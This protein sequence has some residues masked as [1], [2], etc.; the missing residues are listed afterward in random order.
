[1]ATNGSETI[2][3]R[4]MTQEQNRAAIA[5]MV[6]EHPDLAALIPRT[7]G[8]Q[9]DPYDTQKGPPPSNRNRRD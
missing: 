4:A 9:R 7:A 6:E 8:A 2:D 3:V 5:R 1:M